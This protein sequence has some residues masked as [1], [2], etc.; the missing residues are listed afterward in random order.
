MTRTVCY[1]Q[2]GPCD[3]TKM[4]LPGEPR[5]EVY[6]AYMH[7]PTVLEGHKLEDL[8][9]KMQCDKLVYKV[10]G[11][12]TAQGIHVATYVFD[13]KLQEIAGL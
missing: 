3:L 6:M 12:Y 7:Q 9:R 2:G 8:A 4:V 1:L 11:G 5:P 10:V 13:G